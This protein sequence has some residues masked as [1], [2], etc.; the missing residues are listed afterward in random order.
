MTEKTKK[1]IIT[2]EVKKYSDFE[3]LASIDGGKALIIRLEGD[4]ITLIDELISCYKNK[5]AEE[6]MP[7]IAKIE[8]TLDF[9]R[10]FLKASDQKKGAIIALKDEEER[11]IKAES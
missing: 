6:L 8:I 10:T 9:L 4:F 5:K 11:E 7:I 2:T 1:E 3:S